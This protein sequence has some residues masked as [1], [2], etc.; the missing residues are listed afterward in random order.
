MSIF[1]RKPVFDWF[2][3]EVLY[4]MTQS[5]GDTDREV[6]LDQIS[7]FNKVHRDPPDHGMK[8]VESYFYWKSWGRVRRDYPKKFSTGKLEA[9]LG[10]IQIKDDDVRIRVD[11]FLIE[12]VLFS[13]KF[14]SAQEIFRPRSSK[15]EVEHVQVLLS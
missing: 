3:L 5:L 1:T 11:F 6:L 13:I 4:R 8:H 15:Y 9:S 2:E 14:T 7:R 10:W 12:D